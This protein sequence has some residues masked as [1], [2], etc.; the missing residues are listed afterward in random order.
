MMMMRRAW[1]ALAVTLVLMAQ[2][3]APGR[4]DEA[5]LRVGTPA[6]VNFTFLPLQV[7]QQQGFFARQ[8]LDVEITGF[9]GGSRLAQGITAGDVDIAVTSGTDMAFSAKGVP[10][11]AVAATAGPP[12]Y[13]T[14]AVPY[15]SPAKG[16][17]DLKG[18]K[19]AVT[20]EGSFTAWL[21]RRLAQDK[22]WG[23]DGIT[24][25]AVGASPAAYTAALKTGQ[26]DAGV[27][28]PALVYQ[29]EEQ[30]LARP[31][32]PA[33]D[34]VHAFLSNAIFATQ[35]ALADR[36]DD[37][38]RF[39]KGW[40]EAVAFMRGHKAETVALSRS[41]NNYDATVADKEYD[42]VMP[43][44][45]SDGHFDPAA[46]KTLQASFVDMGLFKDPPDMSK[47]YTEAYLPKD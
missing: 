7:G 40:F 3:I 2:G 29:L 36:P 8:G 32:F 47:L 35:K 37:V 16:P 24:L 46:L 10:D 18:K 39:I 42:T 33:S 20:T 12:L 21:M 23:A 11:I 17:D 34:I 13:L 4:A 27:Q 15:A 45:L 28:A 26:V 19:V 1:F 25:V 38:R 6:L 9:E 44:F 41:L 14:V 5:N 30:K 31:L 22:H 43:M